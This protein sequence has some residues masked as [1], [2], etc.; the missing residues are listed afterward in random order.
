MNIRQ[1]EK[2]SKQSLIEL[3]V[4][5]TKM[6]KVNKTFL[7]S[8]ITADYESLLTVCRKDLQK[9][10]VSFD[11]LSLRD[12]RKALADFQKANPPQHLFVELCIYY[13]HLAYE[14]EEIDWRFGESFFSAIEKVYEMIFRAFA[15]DSSLIEAY[16][17]AIMELKN[18]ANEGW[19]HRDY[20][21]ERLEDYS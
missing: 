17:P 18:Q 3:I 4:Q 12:A 13:I 11:K 9:A 2:L 5:M 15:S 1:L 7:E 20:L 6:S 21:E 16:L 14:L 19:G 8:Q 10:F